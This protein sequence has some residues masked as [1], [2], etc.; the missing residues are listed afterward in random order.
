MNKS[1]E[2]AIMR[3]RAM[4]KVQELLQQH[5]TAWYGQE[6]KMD[7]EVDDGDKTSE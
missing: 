5:D 6:L 7:D 4:K 2:L 1:Q 3:I